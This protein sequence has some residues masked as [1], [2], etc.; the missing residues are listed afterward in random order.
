MAFDNIRERFYKLAQTGMSTKDLCDK[1]YIEQNLANNWLNDLKKPESRWYKPELY[2]EILF[3]R[4]LNEKIVDKDVLFDIVALI[5]E[6]FLYVEIGALLGITENEIKSYLET[7]KKPKSP[8]YD[9][10]LYQDIQIKNQENNSIEEDKLYKKFQNLKNRGFNLKSIS[11]HKSVKSFETRQ[12]VRNILL[13]YLNSDMSLTDEFLANKYHVT[14]VTVNNYLMGIDE[15]RLGFA[16]FGEDIMQKIKEQRQKRKE[17]S[18]HPWKTNFKPQNSLSTKELYELS[19]IETNLVFWIQIILTF[20]LSIKEF[21]T[22][23][24]FNN[25]SILGK[26]LLTRS[27]YYSLYYKD[28][29]DFNFSHLK[30]GEEHL[31]EAREYLEKLEVARKSNQKEYYTLLRKVTDQDYKDILKNSQ[32]K[33]TYSDEE[34]RTILEYRLKYALP[35]KEIPFS[36]TMLNKRCPADLKKKIE[37]L[38]EDNAEKRSRLHSSSHTGRSR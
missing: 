8:Y 5:K 36:D 1:L 7:L 4:A 16:L 17:E 15:T 11:N 2:N 30:T 21:A 38:N 19:K 26:V 3:K 10:K 18:V 14:S 13:D 35:W 28:A 37:E 22:L 29:L 6:G 33:L 25:P 24:N 20:K 23:V 32:N 31:T 34:I 9:P 27:E 12:M